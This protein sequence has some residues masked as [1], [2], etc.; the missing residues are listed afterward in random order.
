[1][2]GG[3][4]GAAVVPGN[5][6]ESLL[7]Q[8]LRRSDD[9]SAMPPEKDQALRP[10]QI[11]AFEEWIRLGAPWPESTAEFESQKHWAFLPLQESPVPEATPSH[12]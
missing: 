11:R 7:R 9:V 6:E 1:M 3:E 5:P 12:A 10:D 4:S 8:A 2:Q